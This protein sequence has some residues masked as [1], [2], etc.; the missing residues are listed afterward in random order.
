MVAMRRAE[1][2]VPPVMGAILGD[3]TLVGIIGTVGAR[4]TWVLVMCSGA[5]RWTMKSDN[6]KSI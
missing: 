5:G 6:V 1:T 2:M 4:S 3:A